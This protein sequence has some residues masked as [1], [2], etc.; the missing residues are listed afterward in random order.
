[1]KIVDMHC[2]TLSVLL[3]AKRQG[4]NFDFENSDTQISLSKMQAGDYLLQN[5]AIFVNLGETDSPLPEAL[6]MIL[7][8]ESEMEKHA[9]LIRPV[10]SYADIEQN[11]ADGVMSALL[12]GE[13]GEITMGNPDFL[14]FL[15]KLGMRMMTLTWNYE[16][17]LGFPNVR[18]DKKASASSDRYC[19]NQNKGLKEQG[20]VFLM[21][22]STPQNLSWQAIPMPAVSALQ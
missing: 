2:D 13:E 11:Q 19:L 6:E 1:M 4:K 3:S 5:F 15:Y 17:S 21:Y 14:D 8:F 20:I 22:W 9:D 10:R 18:L 16:N 12:T 7:L